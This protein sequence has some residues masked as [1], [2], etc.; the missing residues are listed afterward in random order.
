MA[1]CGKCGTKVADGARFCPACGAPAAGA[2]QQ[3]QQQPVPGQPAPGYRP[4]VVPGAPAQDD[5]AM[6]VLGYII[7]LIPL[8]A[9][10]ESRF[11]RYHTNQGIV[12]VIFAVA[13][14]ILYNILLAILYGISFRLGWTLGSIIG[15]IGFVF[16]I[17][18]ILGI[19]NACK[20]E[21][22]PLPLIGG[23]TILK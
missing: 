6:A 8:F 16:P 7:F 15:L 9:A 23:I 11:A 1:F 13:W 12:L 5:K 10:K 17:L 2:A 14:G 21:R 3:T 19:I 18:G 4:P 22:K 20:G